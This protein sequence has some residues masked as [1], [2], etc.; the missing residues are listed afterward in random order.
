VCHFASELKHTLRHSKRKDQGE[1]EHTSWRKV[2][3]QATNATAV[4][5]L[6]CLFVVIIFLRPSPIAHI[7][8]PRQPHKGT[9][10]KRQPEEEVSER[11]E[12][13]VSE[14][15]EQK[16]TKPE[17]GELKLLIAGLKC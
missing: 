11:R 8:C 6:I 10:A 13:P 12:S 14:E 4:V 3:Q 16:D 17:K 1:R 5:V 2:E 7:L 15:V 9:K